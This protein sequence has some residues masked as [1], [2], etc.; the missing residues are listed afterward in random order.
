MQNKTNEELTAEIKELRTKLE[1]AQETLDAIRR[2]EVDGLV[3]STT[4]GDQV[5]TITGAEKPYRALIEEMR[6]G[7]VM[8]S[9]DDTILYCNSG[10]AKIVRCPLEKIVGVN[11]ESVISPTHRIAFQKMLSLAR[12]RKSEITKEITLQASGRGFVPTLLSINSLQMDSLTNTFLVVTDLTEHMEEEVKKY[13]SELELAQIALSESE[14]RWATTLASIGD[15]VIATD[16]AGRITFMNGVAEKLTGWTLNEATR[17]PV[18]EIFKIINEFTRKI[19]EDP[20]AKVLEKGMIVGLANHTILVRKDGTEAAID[21]S[22]APIRDKKGKV[23]GV[24]LIFRDITER[25]KAEEILHY[26]DLLVS[27]TSDAIFSTDN[28]FN[29]RS[30]NK[31]AEQIFGWTAEEVIGRTSASIFKPVYPTLD[32]VTREQAIEQ[33]MNNGFWKGDIIYH[34]KDG[35]PIMV[36]TSSSFVKDKNGSAV[37]MVAIVRDITARKRREQALRETQHDLNHAQAVAKTGSWRLDMQRNVLVWSD[38]N[39]R[40]FGVPKGTPMTYEGFLA[41]VHPDDREYVDRKWKA[42]LRGEPYDIEHRLIVNGEV[43]WV[44]ERAELEFS[45]D[46]TLLAGFGTTQEITEIVEMRKKLENYASNMEKLAEERA[47]KLRDAER[48]ATIGATAGMVGH[49]IRNPLQAITGD[50]YLAKS[51]VNALPESE[52]KNSLKENLTAIE[53]NVQYISKIVTD[54]QDYAKPLSPC[55]EKTDLQLVID[56][57]LRKNGLPKNV[58]HEVRVE[59]KAKT[60]TGDSAY[61]KR[62][63]GNLVTNAVQAMPN[64]GKLKIHAYKEGEDAVITVE[65][66]GAGIPEESRSKLF[67]PLF[68]TKSK[69]QG[70]GLAVVKRMTEALNGS[71]SFESQVGEGTTFIVRLPPPRK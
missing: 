60:I 44:R 12:A 46:G 45:K 62:I 57:L 11:I 39:H 71:V 36:S 38:E 51:D 22:G 61:L 10:F 50:V 41:I 56:D 13:T 69:G 49:D 3:V 7:A 67:T 21:D 8:L 54:L 63:I 68:T 31:A 9:D 47:T 6:E 27:S 30:W 24:V 23:T 32:G 26:Y 43:R 40:I 2:G 25:K 16:V 55:P 35:S 19:V 14:Q 48:L 18:Q 58:Q 59:S 64:G 17:R 29:V 52:E 4:K 65:D 15:A 34:K 28:E 1:E 53:E 33:L 20:V 37:G 42:G 70:F 5:Y 66:T